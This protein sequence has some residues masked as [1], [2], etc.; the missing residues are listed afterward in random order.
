MSMSRSPLI[1]VFDNRTMAE[2]AI[3][4]LNDAGFTNDQISYSGAAGSGGGFWQNIKSLFTGNDTGAEDVVNDLVNMGLPE[5]QARYYADQHRAGH[6]IVAVMADNRRDEALTVMRQNGGHDY[7]TR[8]GYGTTTN[9]YDQGTSYS[10]TTN[11]QP[12]NDAD[13]VASG[14]AYPAGTN[15]DTDYGTSRTDVNDRRTNAYDQSTDYTTDQT[16][17]VPIRE[18]RLQAEK[19]RVQAGEVRIGKDV[20][21]EQKN[22]DVPVNREEVV[23]ERHATGERPAGSDIGQDETI[24]VPVSEEQVNVNKQT[25]ETGEVSVGKRTV[26]DTQRVSD[27]VR[28]EEP[29]V[30]RT[31]DAPLRDATNTD[32]TNTNTDTTYNDPNY[33]RNDENV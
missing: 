31:G 28:R 1:G 25:V 11:M 30:E 21:E 2:R 22:I 7:N 17:S 33:R 24:R 32:Y 14:T 19:N 13:Y 3:E 29:R 23:I 4:A 6:P 10:Q 20:V 15:T 26:Q 9:T 16:R 5:D 18:E 8:A 27:T 12:G